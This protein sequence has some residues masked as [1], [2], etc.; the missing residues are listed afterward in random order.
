MP[1]AQNQCFVIPSTNASVVIQA[2]K[3]VEDDVYKDACFGANSQK[4]RYRDVLP[5]ASS[6]VKLLK[7]L[8]RRKALSFIFFHFVISPFDVMVDIYCST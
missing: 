2:L 1:S 8:R 3:S 6:R 5:N 7:S 4:N